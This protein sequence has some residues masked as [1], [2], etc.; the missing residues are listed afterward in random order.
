MQKNKN[1]KNEKRSDAKKS[2]K[3]LT[4][5]DGGEGAA[6]G[7]GGA[8]DNKKKQEEDEKPTGGGGDQSSDDAAEE[9]KKREKKSATRNRYRTRH[10]HD[11][12]LDEDYTEVAEEVEEKKQPTRKRHRLR[13]SERISDEDDEDRTTKPVA[14]A[15]SP[16]S[17]L[18]PPWSAERKRMSSE[19]RAFGVCTRAIKSLA[20]SIVSEMPPI[21]SE[22]NRTS[23]KVFL[24]FINIFKIPQERAE[25]IAHKAVE[26]TEEWDRLEKKW[27]AGTACVGVVGLE[28]MGKSKFITGW[29][30]QGSFIFAKH[31]NF[32]LKMP[33]K[34]NRSQQYAALH[35]GG[36][37]HQG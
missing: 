15:L 27:N 28:K 5:K 31:R 32:F 36:D 12:D 18:D 35:L 4:M 22:P 17:P 34:R 25:G 21:L 29:I 7:S 2:Q 14:V 16:E 23:V 19:C 9:K 30:G 20:D 10:R 1:R 26:Y 6:G 24:K 11:R 13:D 3:N 37:A 8:D 33:R